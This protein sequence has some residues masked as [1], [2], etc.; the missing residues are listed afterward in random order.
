M[1]LLEQQLEEGGLRIQ[2]GHLRI[3]K[4]MIDIYSACQ[5]V[6][7]PVPQY[8]MDGLGFQTIEDN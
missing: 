1:Q 4:T 5:A 8:V 3:T 6:H 7:L 2:E